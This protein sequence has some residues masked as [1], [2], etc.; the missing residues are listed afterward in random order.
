[1][2]AG[3]ARRAGLK[4][5]IVSLIIVALVI[6]I[7][8]FVVGPLVSGIGLTILAVWLIFALFS[9]SFFRDTEPNVP[10]QSDAIVSPAHGTVDLI[11]ETVEAAFMGGPCR[12]ISVFLSVFDVHIQNAPVAGRIGFLKHCPGRFVNA[13]RTNC[14]DYNEN[15]LI[16][17]ESSE[18]PG[19]RL[20]VRLIA[21]LIARRIVPWVEVGDQATKGQRISL[22]QF[23][24]RVDLFLP[25]ST[26]VQV[27][28]GQKVRGGETIVATRA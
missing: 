22:I 1:M 26:R 3:R 12:R 20:A 24:S 10:S 28:L 14:G 11:D 13:M 19:E 21:G 5:V 7:W 27:T 4:I 8:S 9:L 15:V 18:A 25:L 2:N 23:G 6:G 16:G 17:F